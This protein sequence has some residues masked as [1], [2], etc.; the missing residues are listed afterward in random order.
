MTMSQVSVF[1]SSCYGVSHLPPDRMP[2]L[3]GP[4]LIV[5]H[6]SLCPAESETGAYPCFPSIFQ[7]LASRMERRFERRERENPQADAAGARPH[8][9][10]SKPPLNRRSQWGTPAGLMHVQIHDLKHSLVSR[11]L[12]LGEGLPVIG[13][14]PGHPKCR[15]RGA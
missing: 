8:R 10:S 7:T 5:K 4:Y 14:L 1:K 11:A 3:Q 9:Q 2:V 6:S 13:N 15:R 12:R